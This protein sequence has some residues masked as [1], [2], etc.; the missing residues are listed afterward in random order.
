[1]TNNGVDSKINDNMPDTILRSIPDEYKNYIPMFFGKIK[2]ND[3]FVLA[4]PYISKE[5]TDIYK[6]FDKEYEGYN[7]VNIDEGVN[8][9]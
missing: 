8:H 3:C 5:S 4:M 9:S 6:R 2:P 7:A 1:M